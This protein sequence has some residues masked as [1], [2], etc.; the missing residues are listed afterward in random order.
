METTFV[1]RPHHP[2]Y[3]FINLNLHSKSHKRTVFFFLW[4]KMF[5]FQLG[6]IPPTDLIITKYKTLWI[7]FTLYH[8]GTFPVKTTTHWGDHTK[9][10]IPSQT[11]EEKPREKNQDCYRP[12]F[13]QC[14]NP[15]FFENQFER[16]AIMKPANTC[17]TWRKNIRLLGLHCHIIRNDTDDK[18]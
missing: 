12:G 11:G 7:T 15:N 13:H 16:L 18:L 17:G 3:A 14:Y 2:Q 4:T 10:L 5:S 8:D 6:H 9:T 1:T